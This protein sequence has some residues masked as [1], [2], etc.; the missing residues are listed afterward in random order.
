M[1]RAP[2]GARLRVRWSK[3]DRDL[4]F[5]WDLMAQGSSHGGLL[6]YFFHILTDDE[7]LTLRQQLEARGFD[8]TTLRFQIRQ[9]LPR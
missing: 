2:K 4:L 5:A 6:H 7:G 1:S 8:L 9:K 3:R